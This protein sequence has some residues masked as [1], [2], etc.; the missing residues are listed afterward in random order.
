[1]HHGVSQL[2]SPFYRFDLHT[3][4]GLVA[5]HNE[6]EPGSF[7]LCL[8]GSGGQTC[9]RVDGASSSVN[10]FTSGLPFRKVRVE[11]CGRILDLGSRMLPLASNSDSSMDHDIPYSGLDHRAALGIP[12]RL[13]AEG[14]SQGRTSPGGLL[15]PELEGAD[16]KLDA[17]LQR[18]YLGNFFWKGTRSKSTLSLSP[19]PLSRSS[20]DFG[21][22]I[23]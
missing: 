4:F 6:T 13:V 10:G 15:I 7:R 9:W 14:E 8:L 18:A 23:R 11:T 17:S 1:M 12:G 19:L 20:P 21:A 5:S 3:P 2:L 16:A 22:R